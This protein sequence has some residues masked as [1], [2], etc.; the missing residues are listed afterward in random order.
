MLS[1]PGCDA[2]VGRYTMHFLC[3]LYLHV[4]S[5]APC[6]A[7]VHDAVAEYC[8][9][10]AGDA[11]QVTPKPKSGSLSGKF[12]QLS[13]DRPLRKPQSPQTNPLPAF[14]HG[15]GEPGFVAGQLDAPLESPPASAAPGLA[16]PHP[17][18]RIS[19]NNPIYV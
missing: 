7:A 16:I 1:L 13:V 11:V 2:T 8:A 5:G 19:D 14:S 18:R 12:E 10:E 6:Y 4:F 17:E 15:P 9:D 3:A